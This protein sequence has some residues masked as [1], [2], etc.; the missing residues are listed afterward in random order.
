MLIELNIPKSSTSLTIVDNEFIIKEP[1]QIKPKECKSCGI[2]E[3]I[4]PLYDG[5]CQH[6]SKHFIFDE[7]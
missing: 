3:L 2:S 1:K 6:C 5:Y 7:Y 4:T